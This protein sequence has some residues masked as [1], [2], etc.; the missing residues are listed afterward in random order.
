MLTTLQ[1]SNNPRP[2]EDQ[3]IPAMIQA[4]LN[5]VD[6]DTRP[7][8]LMNV[9]VTGASS[10]LYGI[11]DRINMELTSQFPAPRIR[12]S[13]PGNTV[14]RKYAAWIGGSILA[15]LGSF[16]Q[17]IFFMLSIFAQG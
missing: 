8:L 4:A 17:V 14:E 11:T 2:R 12:L 5:S 7:S 10:L 16:H 6:V 13:A 3:T 9:V 15:S 1:D